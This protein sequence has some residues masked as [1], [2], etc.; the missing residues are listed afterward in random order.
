[1]AELRTVRHKGQSPARCL[2]LAALLGFYALG[3][4]L[5]GVLYSFPFFFALYGFGVFFFFLAYYRRLLGLPTLTSGRSARWIVGI[6]P[7]ACFVLVLAVLRNLADLEVRDSLALQAAFLIAWGAVMIWVHVLGSLIGLEPLEHGVEA[8]NPVAVWAGVG[9]MLGATLA[10]AGANIGQGPT[11]ATTLGPMF[12]AVGGLMTLWATF[13][14]VT[15]CVAAVTVDRDLPS[16]L[17]MAA[18]P[19]ALG[20]VPIPLNQQ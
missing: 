12:L 13:C 7:V 3:T 9:L 1:M 2:G 17:R 8:R 4:V 11:V 16:G 14:L 6:T 20:L 5:L 18:L 10:T 19:V 15:G